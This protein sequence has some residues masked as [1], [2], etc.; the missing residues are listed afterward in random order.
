MLTVFW[1]RLLTA[2][3]ARSTGLLGLLALSLSIQAWAMGSDVEGA[4]DHPIVSRFAGS[5]MVGYQQLEFDAGKFFVPNSASGF[6]PAKEIDLDKPVVVEGK[7]TRLIY[8]A[9][10]GKTA[11]EVHRNFEQALRAEGMKM[12]ASVDGRNAWWTISQHWRANFSNA[13]FQPPF[14]RDISPF[15]RRGFYSYGILSRSGVEVSVSV[16]TGPVSL[17]ARDH[18]KTEENTAQAAVAIQIIEPVAAATGQVNVPADVTS[19]GQ[20][21]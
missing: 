5:Q 19:E 14:A 2:H 10:T 11:M 17:L 6:D 4:K 12:V 7:V 18:Y 13:R 1:K 21:A 9:P 3:R 20:E 16:L 15:D 8:V